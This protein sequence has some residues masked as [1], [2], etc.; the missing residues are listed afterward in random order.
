MTKTRESI[1]TFVDKCV[2]I[3]KRGRQE[4]MECY[5]WLQ[6]TYFPLNPSM[7]T[8]TL[9]L[10]MAFSLYELSHMSEQEAYDDYRYCYTKMFLLSQDSPDEVLE[11]ILGG[12][13]EHNK[14]MYKPKKLEK[15]ISNVRQKLNVMDFN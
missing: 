7:W 13:S 12:I 15:M 1:I 6:T 10:L 4:F 2:E 3:S 8:E 11:N 14:D 9:V 5:H